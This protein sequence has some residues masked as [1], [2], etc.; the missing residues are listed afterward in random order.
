MIS[1]LKAE[2]KS[3]PQACGKERVKDSEGGDQNNNNKVHCSTPNQGLRIKSNK[4]S[5]DPDSLGNASPPFIHSPTYA[6]PKNFPPSFLLSLFVPL[7]PSKK[8]VIKN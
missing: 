1:I 5:D 2:D 8:Y 6:A 4:F 7:W 3:D